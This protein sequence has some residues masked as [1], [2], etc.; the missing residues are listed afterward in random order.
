MKRWGTASGVVLAALVVTCVVGC[1]GKPKDGKNG[2]AATDTGKAADKGG[3][4]PAAA[5]ADV[6][7]ALWAFAPTDAAFGLVIGDGV[8]S[9]ARLAA[10]AI[11]DDLGSRPAGTALQGHLAEARKELGFDPLD[12]AGWKSVGIDESKGFAVFVTMRKPGVK[13]DDEHPFMVLPVIDRAAFRTMTKGTT[14]TVD[15]KEVD[16]IKHDLVCMPVGDRYGCAKTVADL[17]VAAAAHD[18]A[19]ATAVKALPADARGDFELYADLARIPDAGEE[20]TKMAPF[21]KME[22]AGLSVRLEN[23]GVVMRGWSKGA[24][25]GPIG[26]SLRSAAPR[27]DFTGKTGNAASVM[28]FTMDPKLLRQQAPPSFMLGGTDLVANLL[29]QLTGELQLVSAGKGL[30]AGVITLGIEDGAKVTEALKAV[31][32]IGKAS[33]GQKGNPLSKLD[34]GDAGCK[35]TLD[36]TEMAKGV[37]MTVPLLPF[38]LKVDGKLLVLGIGDVDPAR[39]AGNAA[40]DAASAETRALLAGPA[41]FVGWSRAF[42]TDFEALPGP[43]LAQLKK[44]EAVSVMLDTVSWLGASVYEI[45]SAFTVQADGA[46]F[47]MRV[48]TFAG[49]PPEARA[50]YMAA[51]DKRHNGDRPGYQS[52]LADVAKKYAGSKIGKRARM[53]SEGT[54][55]LGPGAAVMAGA[56]TT[57]FLRGSQKDEAFSAPAVETPETTE[58]APDAAGGKAGFG[59]KKP[60][61][62]PADELKAPPA[63][64]LKSPPATP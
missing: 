15:G 60:K 1:K 44:Q 49:D 10:K 37:N 9:R 46:T 8:G 51:L 20:L 34:I 38:D 27:A 14:E 39:L 64:E 52:A 63:G 43:F 16:R 23:D 54:P 55:V 47:V 19:L 59:G 45:G 4:P 62:A 33:I 26:Q 57:V 2:P 30:V 25:D 3:V 32:A 6:T 17:N 18:S 36:F 22:A 35:G 11:L 24:V 41:T 13:D 7:S 61:D 53:E 50:A 12:P 42:D 21:G 29:N 28:R 58:K 40:D 56:M 5:H 31:C 48:T